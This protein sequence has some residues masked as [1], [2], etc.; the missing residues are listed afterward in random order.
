[1][2]LSDYRKLTGVFISLRCFYNIN[3]YTIRHSLIGK[4]IQITDGDNNIKWSDYLNSLAR[5]AGKPEIRRNLSKKNALF[6]SKIMDFLNKLLGIKPVLSPIA[7]YIFSNTKKVYINQAKEIL[8]YEPKVNYKDG[9]KHVE[10]WL[11][12]EGYIN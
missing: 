2:F 5:M 1:M 8:N 6:I 11:R 3:I 7:V 9:M 12:E 10:K 4:I